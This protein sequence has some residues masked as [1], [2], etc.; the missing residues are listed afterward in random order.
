MRKIILLALLALVFNCRKS[1]EY[2]PKRGLITEQAMVVSAREEASKIGTD[3]L[4]KGGNVF[5]AMMAT[6]MTLSLT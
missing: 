1:N 4:K 3:I 2:I 5:D 6:E